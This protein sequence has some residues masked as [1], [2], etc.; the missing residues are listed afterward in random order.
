MDST[1]PS[2][3][4]CRGPDS[5]RYIGSVDPIIA[6]VLVATALIAISIFS[7]PS[8][9][10]GATAQRREARALWA[11]PPDAGRSPESVR[12][13][14]EQCKRANIDTIVMLVKGM[15]GEIY[16]QS[17]KFPR[18]VVKSYESFDMLGAL[19]R[20]AHAQNIKVDAWLCDFVEG[21]NGVAFREHPEWAQLNPD[22][23]T[24]ASE[25]L[26]AAR[27]PYPYVWMCPARRPGY[28]D[29]WLL[30][31]IEEIA[32]NYFEAYLD[33]LTETTARQMEWIGRAKPLYA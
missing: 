22:G 13:F 27:R 17:R 29:G 30:P 11:H 4:A 2:P 23:K 24:T 3:R 19:I 20:E 7:A 16:W 21:A 32:E 10:V 26:G 28:T 14:V 33:H 6:S 9:T 15:S 8:S 12:Q 5:L 18:S 31:M 25:T 1:G